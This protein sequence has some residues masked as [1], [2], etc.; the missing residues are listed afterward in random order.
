MTEVTRLVDAPPAISSGRGLRSMAITV[1][2]TR[3]GA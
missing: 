1:R 3:S 2:A